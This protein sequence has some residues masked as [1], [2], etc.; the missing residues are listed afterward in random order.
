MEAA[1]AA[2]TA[3]SGNPL[4]NLLCN[5][6]A[7]LRIS[8]LLRVTPG[9]LC[10]TPG[11]LALLAVLDFL[12][13][14]GV[15]YL[16]VGRSGSFAASA[17][18]G[19]FFHLPL[20]LF[21]GYLAARLLSRPVL[22]CGLAVAL[23]SLSIPIELGHALLERLA[24]FRWLEWLQ[25]YLDAPHYYRFY[26]WWGLCGLLF[27]L[28]VPGTPVARRVQSALLLVLVALVPL[29]FFSRADLWVSAGQGGSESGELQL[30]E[31]VLAAQGRLLDSQLASLLP[32]ER[33]R[34]HFY[35]VG[36]AGDATQDVFLKEVL[37]AQQVFDRR[38]RTFGR[39]L[40]LANNP[41]SASTLPFASA[42][43]LE[44]ALVRLGQVM[45][46]DSDVLVLF[47]TSH[48]S[49]DHELEVS[50]PPLDL[51]QVTPEMV[52]KMLAKSGIRWKVLVVSA[53]FSGGFIDPL[54]G[55]DTLIITA[56]DARSESFGCGFGEKFT[57]FGEAFLDR[58]LKSSFSFSDAFVK[59]RAI[60][61][62]W[63]EEQ[64]ETP[65]NPQIWVGRE[66]GRK[67]RQMEP[68]LAG[69]TK[70]KARP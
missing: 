34:S 52:R 31:S 15:S 51:D 45:N 10:V 40:V 26:G 20:V 65:S 46:R 69:K 49:R 55:E 25:P 8:L 64:G 53:C 68:E 56:A 5:L 57:W 44:K 30:N 67:L 32:G 2:E 28:R 29:W 38:F 16:L 61:R 18:P 43:N 19:F 22:G 11:A 4:R 50:N 24:L 36:F 12:C 7:G 23:V 70:V 17:V 13:N 37:A 1:E 58:G 62:K 9:Q 47:L 39:S 21:A 3:V 6:K 48:G 27:L 41:Q 59:A 14:L 35:F 60:I 63:E 33:G 66:I 54:K 42:S